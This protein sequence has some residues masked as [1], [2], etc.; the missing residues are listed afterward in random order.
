MK[1][2]KVEVDVN[3]SAR[4]NIGGDASKFAR[5]DYVWFVSEIIM[6]QFASS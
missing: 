2:T 3:L 1:L 6:A 4:H 5:S